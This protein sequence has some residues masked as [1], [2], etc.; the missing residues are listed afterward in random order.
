MLAAG[1]PVTFGGTVGHFTPAATGSRRDIAVVFASAW[2]LEELCTRKFLRILADGLAEQGIA[3]LRFD[4]P[5]SGDSLDGLDLSGGL[6]VWSDSL[7]TAI[8][9]LRA[10]S[11]CERVAIVTQ[12]VGS[13]VASHD[14]A[15]TG[16]AD[17]CLM[18]PVLSGRSHLREL[19]LW[20][21]LV[22][23]KL[24]LAPPA[25][26]SS[27]ITI[28]SLT[29]PPSVA[30]DIR[31]ANLTAE[32]LRGAERVLVVG[33]KDKPAEHDLAVKLETAEVA[34]NEL[35]Y[36]GYDQLV[37]NPATALMPLGVADGICAWLT[38][39]AG[40]SVPATAVL[41]LPL[42][43]PLTGPGFV[44][45]PVR[46]G[47]DGHLAGIVCEPLSTR[48]GS[49]VLF[50]TSAYDR[51]AGWGRSTLTM[52]RRLAQEGIA[53]LRFDTANVGDS[54][55]VPGRCEQVLYDDEQN[56]DVVAALD[57]IDMRGLGGAVVSG[58]CSGAF[59]GFR[60]ALIDERIGAV[61]AVNAPVFRWHAGRSV[62]EAVRN[63]T[64]SLADY[65]KRAVSRDTLRRLI[66]GEINVAAASQNIVKGIGGRIARSVTFR[67]RFL[68]EEGRELRGAFRSLASRHV[69]VRLLYSEHDIGLE[70][71]NFYF[72]DGG[73]PLMESGNVSTLI[74]P[75]ADHNF[76]PAHAKEAYI[77][78]VRDMALGIPA[79]A[80]LSKGKAAAAAE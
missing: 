6:G 52:A 9:K 61:C 34:V 1:V 78:A 72:A 69:P 26:L 31:K 36:D 11:G 13:L 16:V 10:Y 70:H 8:S 59:L 20:S 53:S 76:T 41:A 22:D 63:S 49:T 12:G 5:G 21:R 2:G 73:S 60:A 57:F 44:E 71:Y 50:L 24:G 45:T 18:A 32:A 62:E 58:R 75:D 79:V 64:R 55:A 39:I 33:R 46:F 68:T 38:Q 51:H 23:E 25:E 27:N 47:L 35:A 56:E 67:F 37:S 19:S 15:R 43:E 74:V 30:S 48:R 7:I 3:S 29:M 80:G 77:A 66:R 4:Y 42:T 17:L 28:A 40:P 14:L 65:G 54:P